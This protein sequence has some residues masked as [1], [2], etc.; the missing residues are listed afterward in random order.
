MA[1]C[2]GKAAGTTCA[3]TIYKC[4]K[5][6]LSGCKNVRNGQKCNNNITNVNITMI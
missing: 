5:C 1:N 3:G 4:P 6:G 2:H